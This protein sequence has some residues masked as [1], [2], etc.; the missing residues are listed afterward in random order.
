[1]IHLVVPGEPI[2]KARPRWSQHGTYTPTKTVNYETQIKERFA[3][4]HPGHIPLTCAVRMEVRAFFSIP[5]SASRTKAE[6]M[7]L[8]QITPTKKPDAD[9]C[10]KIVADA[11]NGIAYRD[12]S[13]IVWAEIRKGYS[14][15][16]RIEIVIS[17]V[18]RA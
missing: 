18:G 1:V 16:P 5:K 6:A 4:E 12:D 8:N 17:Q 13:Q 3:A 7:R 9:N 15:V 2:G 10:L 11:L 14:E